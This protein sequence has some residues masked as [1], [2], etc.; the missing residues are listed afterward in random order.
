VR[1]LPLHALLHGPPPAPARIF[2]HNLWF[3]GHNNPRY[4]ELLPR[5]ERLDAYVLVLPDRPVLR[6]ASWRALHATRRFRYR[7]VGGA[8][9]RRYRAMLTTDNEQIPY[10]R[11]PIVSD[12]DDPHYSPREVALLNR[13]HVA[14]YVVTTEAAARRFESLGVRKPW[15]VVPQGVSLASLARG[16]LESARARRRNGE[17]V[18]GYIGSWLLSAGDRGGEDPV[19][20]VDHLLDLW[21][22]IHLR[23]QAARLWLIGAAGER[24]VARCSGRDDILLLGRLPRPDA[25]AHVASFD[26]ALYPRRTSHVPQAAKTV[27]YLGAGVPVVSYDLPVVADLREAGAG[28]LVEEP[29]E[30]VAAV[31]MLARDRTRRNALADVA[32]RAGAKRDWDVLAGEYRR[33]LDECLPVALG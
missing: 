18:V 7:V 15:Y 3:S 31:E 32:K 2:F 13:P 20:N 4:A 24:I 25:L 6:G 14:A 8:A 23:I 5:L 16:D 27:E 26:I 30:F 17:L 29:R 22:E 10:F 19:R 28:I 33:I 1:R 12:V 9:A 11:R 21:D